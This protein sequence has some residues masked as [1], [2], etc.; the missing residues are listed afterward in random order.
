MRKKVKD[1]ITTLKN[2][3]KEDIENMKYNCCEE[4]LTSRSAI[5]ISG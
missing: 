1:Q 4:K 3:Q 5:R 2:T